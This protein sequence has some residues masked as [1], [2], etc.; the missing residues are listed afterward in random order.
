MIRTAPWLALLAVS[1]VAFST[2]GR[3]AAAQTGPTAGVHAN[4]AGSG[5]VPD[6]PAGPAAIRGRVV[7]E[8]RPEAA[9]GVPVALFA[10]GP[11]GRP[12]TRSTLTGPGGEFVFEKITNDP[13]TVYLIAV[14]FAGM[15]FGDR[16]AFAEG[17][18]EHRSEIAI[19]DTSEDASG[20][21]V[22]AVRLRVDRGCSGVRVTEVYELRNPTEFVLFVPPAERGTR[23]PIFRTSL[24]AAA[25]FF[26]AR[27][28]SSEEGLQ[29]RGEEVVF[30]GG[31][32]PGSR[33][34][35]FSYSIPGG[36]S[37]LL[38]QRSFS[39]GAE[40]AVVMT[41]AD[42]PAT[43]GEGL[44]P[45]AEVRVGDLTYATL[46]SGALAPGDGVSFSL[47]LG[48]AAAS[49]ER[50][51]LRE[52]DMWM[53]LDDAA[54]DVREQFEFVVSGD[55]PLHS[56]SDA[57]LLCLPLPPE[58]EGLRFS[59]KTLAMGIEPDATGG[60]AMR[61][62]FPPGKSTFAMSYLLRSESDG[63][64]FARSY[65]LGVPLLSMFIA[66]TGLLT[67]TDRLHRRRPLRT[68]DRTYIHLEAFEIE[69][70]ETVAVDL[71]STPSPRPL[72][73]VATVGFVVAAAVAALSFLAA[74]LRAPHEPAEDAAAASTADERAAV[75]AAILD[76]EDDFETGK[77][78]AEDRAV[79]RAELR[80][81]AADLLRQE[82]AAAEP[83]S[84]A[85]PSAAEQPAAERP[86]VA[87]APQPCPGCGATIQAGARF[88][89]RCGAGLSPPKKAG[90][91]TG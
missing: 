39:R 91:L 31:L 10:L 83:P 88:C 18:L 15:P 59:S 44:R 40:K 36:R 58:A 33:E 26:E 19:S 4:L 55:A 6:V 73:R 29:R 21:T 80:A 46:E 16:V 24:P 81:Q 49:A 34:V 45:G 11:D 35:E 79:M 53:E 9:Q 86:A 90:D 25:D 87:P 1:L 74:P 77:I 61:G 23:E 47:D 12:G 7:H 75:Y 84:A 66:D 48:A 62:P 3:D 22:G 50:L 14:R 85:P 52:V 82:R 71:R 13:G 43:P 69:P 38:M 32:L 54:L 51:S 60:L 27:V 65:P 41:W 89:S 67:E 42:E 37:I 57:P 72:P 17:E 70:G 28:G 64:L 56:G 78:S 30:W 68:S 8:A 76:L 5:K 2:G 20:L 63:I